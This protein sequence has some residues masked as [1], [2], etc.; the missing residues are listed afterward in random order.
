M[1][2]ILGKQKI[3]ILLLI[4]VAMVS[5][6][7]M[8][9]QPLPTHDISRYVGKTDAR[10]IES[11]ATIRRIERQDR[12]W[13]YKEIGGAIV[14]LVLIGL[15]LWDARRDAV[16]RAQKLRSD[17]EGLMRAHQPKTALARLA[18]AVLLA[19]RDV[20]LLNATGHLYC[21]QRQFADAEKLFERALSLRSD[22]ANAMYGKGLCLLDR[23]QKDEAYRTLRQADQAG[24]DLGDFRLSLGDLA[25]E[26]GESD[27]A[28]KQYRLYLSRTTDPASR[29]KVEEL[30]KKVTGDTIRVSSPLD[31]ETVRRPDPA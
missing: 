2:R 20:D 13:R 6:I 27:L 5:L 10:S 1:L 8:A 12:G 15:N 17:A 9:A 28:E 30:L 26:R 19:P 3:A 22:D 23:G 25:R 14:L 7:V 16:V 21:F 29:A 11:L 24:C 18:E 31:S 4:A